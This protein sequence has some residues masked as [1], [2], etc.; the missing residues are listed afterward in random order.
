MLKSKHV[1][2]TLT[3]DNDGRQSY[4][5]GSTIR[6]TVILELSKD[7]I[8]INNISV[9]FQGLATVK[10]H[11]QCD[12][13]SRP[14]TNS[15]SILAS[16]QILW[17]NRD[18]NQQFTCGLTAGVYRFPFAFLIPN[19]IPLPSSLEIDHKNSVQYSLFAGISQSTPSVFNHKTA[20]KVIQVHEII[21]INTPNLTAPLS[22]TEQK[23]IHSFFRSSG[24]ISFSVG[25]QRGGYCLGES[26]AISATAENL[27]KKTIIALRASLS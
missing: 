19:G 7:M 26:I 13:S 18:H 14:F 4:T 1:N 22:A 3:V 12:G 16:T 11:I 5:S 24:S 17:D 27:S 9:I 21:D 6:G 2:F 23:L 25:I 8:P 15:K 10:F 20:I